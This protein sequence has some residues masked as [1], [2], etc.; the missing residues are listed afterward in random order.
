VLVANRQ[1]EHTACV[2][3]FRR[4]FFGQHQI[5]QANQSLIDEFSS[6]GVSTDSDMTDEDQEAGSG[7]HFQDTTIQLR[8]VDFQM[9]SLSLV[10]L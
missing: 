5:T 8:S 10:S 2:D 7:V 4:A 3:F 1:R 9:S 6:M